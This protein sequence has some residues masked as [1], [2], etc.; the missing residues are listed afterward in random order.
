[1]AETEKKRLEELQR[2]HRRER[3]EAKVEFE[4]NFFVKANEPN[5]WTGEDEIRY[6]LKQG[7]S[8]Y[9]ERRQRLDWTG[10]PDIFDLVEQGL[11]AEGCLAVPENDNDQ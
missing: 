3:E 5:H 2:K 6:C 4:P 8:G 11:I 9:W 7:E 10:L 1:M